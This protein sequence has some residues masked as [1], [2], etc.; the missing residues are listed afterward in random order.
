MGEDDDMMNEK[1]KRELAL[2]EV[3]LI[4]LAV[5]GIGFIIYLGWIRS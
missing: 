4:I 5:L 2:S 1:E 3:I